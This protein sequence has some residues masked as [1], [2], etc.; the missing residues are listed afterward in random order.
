MVYMVDK[1]IF[2]DTP[3]SLRN[4]KYV[5]QYYLKYDSVEAREYQVSLATKALSESSVIALPTGTGKTII[6]LLATAERIREYEDSKVL[7]LAPLKPLV[8]QQAESFREH[9]DVRDSKI[10]VFTGDVRPEKREQLWDDTKIVFATPQVIE[11]DIISNRISLDSVSY[12][13][14]DECHRATGNYSYTF[15]AEE[16]WDSAKNPLVTG[17]SAS[18]GSNKSNILEICQNLGAT[19]LEVLSE[20]DDI[21]QEHLHETTVSGEFIDLPDE[22][23]EVKNIIDS[24]FRECTENLKENGY[25]S[26]V[27]PSY[28]Q[29]LH[30]CRNSI[31]KDIDNGNESAGYSA[32]SVHAEAI[33]L[34]ELQEI[35]AKRGLTEVKEK[36][37]EWREEVQSSS[38]SSKALQRVVSDSEIEKVYSIASG[39][40]ETHPKLKRL[41]VLLAECLMD[42]GNA[43]VFCEY[44]DSVHKIV[45]FLSDSNMS[46]YAFVGQ[47]GMTRK[48]QQQVLDNFRK[49]EFDVLVSTKVAEEGLDLPQVSRIIEYHPVASGLRKVQ[50]AGRTGRDSSGEVFILVNSDTLEEGLYYASMNNK[51]Q[52]EDSLKELKKMRSDILEELRE[53]QDYLRE[54]G[55]TKDTSEEEEEESEQIELT[56]VET[57]DT[58]SDKSIDTSSVTDSDSVKVIIDSREMNSSIGRQLHKLESVAVEMEQLDVGDYILG[59]ECAAERKSIE[60]FL[61]TLTGGDRSLFEQLGDL[62]TSYEK[63]ILLLEGDKSK[64]YSGRVHKNAINGAIASIQFDFGVNVVYTDS[65]EDTV[66]WIQ[67]IAEREQDDS[68]TEVQ[69]H[70]TKSTQTVEDQQE[71]I[72]SSFEGIGPKTAKKLLQQFT[73]IEDIIT[74]S[75]EELQETE[76]VGPS[77]A[78]YIRDIVETEYKT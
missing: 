14:F 75:A 21:L 60:D 48:E 29:L 34:Y 6:S 13:V 61:D 25:L 19:N 68:D 22:F 65:E 73:S 27:N 77:T 51:S 15:I 8:K 53:N 33:K 59:S 52:M 46:A 2:E 57:T 72:V 3:F 20:D 24:K 18:P 41:R 42:G 56:D 40:S 78:E 63:P 28:K 50:R 10:K 16:Y 38:D 39:F 67:L 74:A 55:V 9:L 64:L 44:I 76:T 23:S 26:T 1:S 4:E 31:Q 45:D 36:I 32:M 70:G 30:G 54:H 62:A 58:G 71:Y 12:T 7:F 11:N 5:N 43:I 47:E 37:D 69:A 17:L 66:N 49:G 35:I